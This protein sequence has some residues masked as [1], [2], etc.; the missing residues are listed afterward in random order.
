MIAPNLYG[1]LSIRAGQVYSASEKD[2]TRLPMKEHLSA[3]D[4][5][6]ADWS[7]GSDVYVYGGD[8]TLFTVENGVAKVNSRKCIGCGICV[9]TCPSSVIRLINDT[10]RV[11]VK[12][13]NHD[14]GAQ[15]RKYCSNGC[16]G[17]MKCQK[18]CPHGAITVKNNL[19]VIDYDK[20][21]G[22]GECQAACPVKCIH[23]E[24]FVC[25]THL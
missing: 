14:K 7:G 15:T 19:A 22:C 1:G 2:R 20:C 13:S 5:I 16:I 12:C 11:V 3:G 23:I 9:R 8:K 18:T 21:T 10:S 17:C 24:N 25:G 6:L 4:I